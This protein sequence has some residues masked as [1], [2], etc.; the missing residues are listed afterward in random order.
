[1][2]LE[3]EAVVDAIESDRDLCEDDAHSNVIFNEGYA[4][5]AAER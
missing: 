3:L 4:A 5:A 2:L 1:M